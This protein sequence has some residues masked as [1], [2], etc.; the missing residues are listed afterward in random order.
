MVYAD[1]EAFTKPIDNCQPNPENS[2]TMSYQRHVA[3]SFTFYIKCFDDSIYDSKLVTYTAVNENDDVA[4]K[5]IDMLEEEVKKIYEQVNFNKPMI[6]TDEDK[7]DFENSTNCHIC[8]D[9]L[10]EDRV[11]DHCH[12]SG[13]FRGAAHNNCNLNYRVRHVIPI[14]LHNLSNYDAHLFIKRFGNPDENISCIAKNS[15]NY[16]TFGKN[17]VVGKYT[18]KEGNKKNLTCDLKF[19]DSFR[20][21]SSSLEALTNNLDKDQCK[22]LKKFYGESQLEV[23]KRKDV[24]PYDYV[25]SVDKL[26]DTTLP[27]KEAFY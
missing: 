19:V 3:S 23:L 26:A 4:Q 24:Y 27:P 9:K 17:I 16:I 15:E 22:N 20:F 14:F 7:E 18:D 8:G 2:Y 6:L 25:D 21:M 10:G 5:F 13:K 11:R 12:L 1:F